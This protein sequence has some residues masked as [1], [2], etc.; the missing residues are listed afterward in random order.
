[1]KIRS[2]IITTAAG[3]LIAAP[4]L[5]QQPP[6]QPAA[7]APGH[8]DGHGRHGMRG[9]PGDVN[10]DGNLTLAELR[11]GI[12]DRFQKMDA[13]ADGK[14]DEA[15]RAALQEARKERWE[16]RKAKMAERGVERPERSQRG[17]RPHR[18]ERG[19]RGKRGNLDANGDGSI[20]LAELE[21]PAVERF[22]RMDTNG[23]GT[24]TKAEHEAAR[25]AMKARWQ[26]RKAD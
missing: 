1:M 2:L 25:A 15:E 13:N 20:T 7:D 24:V 3:L 9:L 19:E 21:A 10:E 14:V 11:A 17:E 18:G 8:G 26:E 4:T 16:A 6:A 5:A 22:Q 23:D 12:A